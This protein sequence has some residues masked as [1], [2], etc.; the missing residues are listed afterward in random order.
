MYQYLDMTNHSANSTSS[1]ER[2]GVSS[3][4][5]YSDIPQCVLLN[6]KNTPGE[7][8]CSAKETAFSQDSQSGMTSRPSTANLGEV[9][10]TLS[11]GD[12]HAKTS[13]S[14]GRELGSRASDLDSGE[15]WRELSV[16][17]DLNT[18]SWK[19]HQCLWEEDLPESSVTLP[20]WGMMQNGV[21]W[22]RTT[23]N[24]N[25]GGTGYGS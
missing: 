20:K 12:S 22:E 19:T 17:F 14:L 25:I 1:R 9:E 7:S 6:S 21:C 13:Q 24:L 2:E 16:R 3:A 4:E 23:S 11:L 18:S 8:C 15:R 10:L 5:C